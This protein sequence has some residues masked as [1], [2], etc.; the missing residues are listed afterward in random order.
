MQTMLLCCKTES[1]ERTEPNPWPATPTEM[2]ADNAL[3]FAVS[4]FKLVAAFS[5]D[6]SSQILDHLFWNYLHICSILKS[7]LRKSHFIG[8]E[9]FTLQIKILETIAAALLAGEVHPEEV[10]HHGKQYLPSRVEAEEMF[11]KVWKLFISYQTCLHLSW[12]E[13]YR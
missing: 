9:I 6:S 1:N 3:A 10:F 4:N 2:C 7:Y 13:L 5:V 12:K 8:C 11:F